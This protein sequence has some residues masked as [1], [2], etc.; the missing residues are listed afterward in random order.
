VPNGNINGLAKAIKNMAASAELREKFAKHSLAKAT[1]FSIHEIA[2]K[3]DDVFN[4]I[5]KK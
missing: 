2:G 3:W 1:E 4:I 5:L